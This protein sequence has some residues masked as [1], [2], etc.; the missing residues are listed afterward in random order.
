MPVILLFGDFLPV[1]PSST[2]S[3]VKSSFGTCL[4]QF[5]HYE[6][7]SEPISPALPAVW[8]RVL[9]IMPPCLPVSAFLVL[10][11]VLITF[12]NADQCLVGPPCVSRYIFVHTASCGDKVSAELLRL[13]RTYTQS[14]S[15]SPNCSVPVDVQLLFQCILLFIFALTSTIG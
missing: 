15:Q 14:S 2:W 7:V 8:P 9:G 10:L 11:P 3:H 4:H 5:Q 12:G 13:F 1:A 6:M